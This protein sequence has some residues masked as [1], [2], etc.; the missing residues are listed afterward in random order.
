MHWNIE[1]L[2]SVKTADLSVEYHFICLNETFA[3]KQFSTRGFNSFH[4][5]AH[6]TRGRPSGGVS[7][8][9]NQ[10]LDTKLNLAY[11]SQNTLA[12]ELPGL[13]LA[14]VA[15]Y[16][17]PKSELDFIL[18]DISKAIAVVNDDFNK[19]LVGD[20]NC[21]LDKGL[22]GSIL[23]DLLQC[24]QFTCLN[25]PGKYTYHSPLGAST[26]RYVVCLTKRTL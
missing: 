4:A 26:I 14:I 21:R 7:A 12:V 16:M 2:S 18:T 6:K 22:R 9:I 25:E 1:G 8:L 13:N 24:L 5:L 20:F 23:C 15:A 19:I 3:L 11:S 17:K 10:Y